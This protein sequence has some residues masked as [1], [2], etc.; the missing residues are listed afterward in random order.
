MCVLYICSK[1]NLI[2]Y[3]D[4]LR[5]CVQKRAHK[6]RAMYGPA[7]NVVVRH[8]KATRNVNDKHRTVWT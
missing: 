4:L 6:Y 1:R 5:G 3:A 8:R 7:P 2:S